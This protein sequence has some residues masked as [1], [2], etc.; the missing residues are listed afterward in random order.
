VERKEE[1][2]QRS[3]CLLREEAYRVQNSIKM[4][5][6]NKTI[7]QRCQYFQ[8]NQ[9]R[10]INLLTNNSKKSV[11]INRVMVTTEQNK[12]IETNPKEIKNEVE[13]Y[14]TKVFKRRKTDFKRLNES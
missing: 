2:N 8:S 13:K 6:I 14:F 11:Q 7:K 5:E 9:R 3:D 10:M 4:K 1:R 12:Y